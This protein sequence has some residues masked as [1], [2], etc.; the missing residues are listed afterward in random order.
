VVYYER[1][2]YDLA[3]AEQDRALALSPRFPGG[4]LERGRAYAGKHDQ[5]RALADYDEAI[6]INP[7]YAAP[8]TRAASSLPERPARCRDR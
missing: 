2:D 6:K 8:T 3:I 1:K 5:A 4:Y 7:K